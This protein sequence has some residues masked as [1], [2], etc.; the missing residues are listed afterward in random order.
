MPKAVEEDC[1]VWRGWPPSSGIRRQEAAVDP[2]L[3]GTWRVE[4]QASQP[5]DPDDGQTAWEADA[6]DR[7]G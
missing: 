7:W 6:Y 3:G 2:R 5:G 4:G 1:W